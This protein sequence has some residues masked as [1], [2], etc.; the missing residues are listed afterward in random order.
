M[1][2]KIK[3]KELAAELGVNPK[4]I[5][6]KLREHGVQAK[7]T[8]ADIDEEHAVTI[9]KELSGSPADVVRREVQPGVIVRRR[10]GGRNTAKAEKSEEKEKMLLKLQKKSPSRPHLL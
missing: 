9:R 6:Q 7:S 10:K 5:L 2:S 1:A 8:V 4:D 3:V